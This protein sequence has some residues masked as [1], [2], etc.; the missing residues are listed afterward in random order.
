[1]RSRG[2]SGRASCSPTSRARPSLVDE[3]GGSYRYH[4]LLR[5][6][7]QDELEAREPGAAP[8]LH[9]RAARWYEEAGDLDLA[10][11]HAFAA[12]DL[13]H[14][15]ALVGA[16]FGRYHWSARRVTV[17]AWIGRFGDRALEERPWL[18]VLGAWEEIASGDLAATEHLADI[19]ER[20][21]F[22]GRPPDGTASFESGRAMLRSAMCRAGADSSL[23]DATRAVALEP[24][25]SGWRDFA[26]W[27]LA[28]ARLVKGDEAAA[29]EAMAEA[30]AAARTARNDGLAYAILG[31][32]ALLAMDRQDWAAADAYVTDAETGTA[33]LQVEGYL[34]SALACVARARIAI[35]RGD[36]GTARG[37]CCGASVC[38][39]C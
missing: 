21:S 2:Q 37:R 32:R 20:G 8:V 15:A 14:A 10:V 25:D 4:S 16:G 19:A 18:A 28:F 27:L 5:E 3:Y 38:G 22:P 9:G 36:L 24:A 30:I 33:A 31:H 34:S 35:H 29:D 23:A 12:H 13:D 1:M 7:L 26:L 17:Q 11:A 6:F 39:R